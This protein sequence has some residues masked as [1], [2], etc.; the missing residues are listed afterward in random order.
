MLRR[1]GSYFTI[2][3][4]LVLGAVTPGPDFSILNVVKSDCLC[5]FRLLKVAIL[6]GG[7]RGRPDPPPWVHGRGGKSKSSPSKSA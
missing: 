4:L 2:M 3:C 6:E 5:T 1:L 7:R